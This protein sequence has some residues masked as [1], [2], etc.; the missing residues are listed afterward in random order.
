VA[1][2]LIRF[3]VCDPETGYCLVEALVGPGA[4]PPPNRHPADNEAFYVLDGTF[5]FGIGSENRLATAGEFVKVPRGR[6]I[7][8]KT[9]GLIRPAF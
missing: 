9:S 3:L 6:S 7:P 2:I 8:S 5:E 1:G 4:G